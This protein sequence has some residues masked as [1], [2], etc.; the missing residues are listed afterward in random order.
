[1]P[2]ATVNI[3]LYCAKCNEGLCSNATFSI[4]R[5]YPTFTIEPCEN[6]LRDE[7]DDGYQEGHDDAQKEHEEDE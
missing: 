1:M 2:E 3:E 6:C 4:Y 7:R 5:G